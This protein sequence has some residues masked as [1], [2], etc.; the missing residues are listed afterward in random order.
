MRVPEK[1]DLPAMLGICWDE[2]FREVDRWLDRWL[3]TCLD[4]SLG[5]WLHR[6]V[7]MNKSWVS[8]G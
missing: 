1:G 2:G 5:W 3:D 8:G 7:M 6:Q 4:R